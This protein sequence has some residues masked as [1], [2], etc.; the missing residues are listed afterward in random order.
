MGGDEFAAILPETAAGA[1]GSV[2]ENLRKQLVQSM[3]KG[4]WPV[5]VSIGAVTFEAPVDTSREALRVAD[6]A[7]Y[8][9]KR[10]GKDGIHH[11]VWDGAPAPS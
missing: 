6:E 8:T 5:A 1:T 10:S 11:V 4:G 2:L 3:A 9:V 7:M